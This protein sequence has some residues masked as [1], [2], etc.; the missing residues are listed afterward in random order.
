MIDLSQHSGRLILVLGPSG[1][2]KGTVFRA[3]KER[4]PDYVFPLSCTTR[5]PRPGEKEGEVYHFVSKEEFESRKEAGEFLEWANVHGLHYYGT[6]KEAILAP[7]REGKVVVREV[8]VQGLKSIRDLIPKSHLKS[9]FLTVDGWETLRRR[10]LQRSVLP[11]EELERR[12]QSFLKEMEWAKE[13]DTVILSVEGEVDRL[14]DDV[15]KGI[16]LDLL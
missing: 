5:E 16:E 15:E 8:D 10:I 14:I 13:C 12:R 7:M 1:S 4:H 2:G 6:L 11:E 3:L 9:I